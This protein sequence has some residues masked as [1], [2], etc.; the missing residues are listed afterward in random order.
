MMA[1]AAGIGDDR[2][3]LLDPRHPAF[4]AHPLFPVAFEWP[5]VVALGHV[6]REAGIP[7]DELARGVHAAHDLTLHRPVREGDD[8][9]TTAVL[10]GVEATRAGA[11]Q[12]VELVTCDASGDPVCTTLMTSVLLGVAVDGPDVPAPPTDVPAVA[13]PAS[14]GSPD[15]VVAVGRSWARGAAHV[16]TECA[17]IWNPIH[18]D[19]RRAAAA[20]LPDIVLHG[21]ATLARAVSDAVDAAGADLGGVRRVTGRLRAPVLLPSTVTTVI[22]AAVDAGSGDQA[23]SVE[24]RTADGAPALASGLVVLRPA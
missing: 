11:R 10:V 22:G 18:T 5:A 7:A 12:V 2:T 4:A 9:V 8:L 14:H 24:V 23:V 3:E 6:M 1:Y 20:G 21:T 15:R 13:D 19:V 17:R 16:Y